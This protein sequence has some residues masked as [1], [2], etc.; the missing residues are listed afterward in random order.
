[1]FISIDCVWN[2]INHLTTILENS[3]G[4]DGLFAPPPSAGTLGGKYDALPRQLFFA[5]PSRR[6]RPVSRT[7]PRQAVRDQRYPIVEQR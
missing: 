6:H 1:M 2:I 7:P 4:G 3:Q 5:L